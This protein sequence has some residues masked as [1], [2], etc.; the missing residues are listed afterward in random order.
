MENATFSMG[1][2]DS[3]GKLVRVLHQE[4]PETDFFPALNGLITFWDGKDDAGK[5]MP[6]G[7]YR[8]KG[9]MCGE[10]DF[11]GVA[12]LFNDWIT[13]EKSPHISHIR[14]IGVTDQGVL[15]A[16][17]DSPGISGGMSSTGPRQTF[18]PPSRSM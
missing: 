7:K 13:D 8:A 15:A 5:M 9:Y 4:A 18:R 14:N 10:M 12:F 6:A 1:I 2:Y 17:Y 16:N 3:A 11:E